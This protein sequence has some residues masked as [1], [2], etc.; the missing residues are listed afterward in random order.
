MSINRVATRAGRSIA[1]ILTDEASIASATT[2]DLGS[3]PHQSIS[4][5]GTTTITAFG[6]SAMTGEIKF[7][8]FAGALTLTHNATSLILPGGANITTAAGDCA[9]ARYEGSSNWRVLTYSKTDGTPVAIPSNVYVQGGTD[10]AIADGGTGASTATAAFDNLSPLTTQGD[11]LYHNGTDNVRLGAGTS[12]QFLKTQG[13]GAN[14]VWADGPGVVLLS[15]GSASAVATVDVAI[16]SGYRSVDLRFNGL[17]P[18][19][20]A[21]TLYVRLSQSG[22]YLAGASDYS[23]A[24]VVANAA[25][26]TAT[27]DGADS[28]IELASNVDNG[29]GSYCWGSIAIHNADSSSIRKGIDWTGGYNNGI[30]SVLSL[31]GAGQIIANSNA[32]DGV[33]LLF[34]SGNV[35]TATYALYG[36][37]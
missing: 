26:A 35:A 28:E 29:A 9:T 37:T 25:G 27:G 18:A 11:V 10:V 14:P 20:D 7:I 16:P 3:T 5:T 33:R 31:W 1:N 15:S 36:Y 30:G 12:G 34:S 6:S 19:T 2:T 13:A 32:V 4:I 17:T 24:Q 23:W 22:S 8:K 21:V